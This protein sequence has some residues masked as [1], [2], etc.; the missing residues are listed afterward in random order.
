M[1]FLV[2]ILLI[3]LFIFGHLQVRAQTPGKPDRSPAE[4]QAKIPPFP[5]KSV[6]VK[7]HEC[8]GKS[9]VG[10]KPPREGGGL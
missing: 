3:G 5:P 4:Q 8:G 9:V 10:S 7:E 6:T 2:V 1:P